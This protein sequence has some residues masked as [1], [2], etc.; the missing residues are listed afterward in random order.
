MA[1]WYGDTKGLM[2]QGRVEGSIRHNASHLTVGAK[3]KVKAN[4]H[5]NHIVVQGEVVG[6]LFGTEAVIIEASARVRGNVFAPRV[7]LHEGAKFKGSIDM[8]GT[9]ES[10]LSSDSAKSSES[11]KSPARSTRKK[12]GSSKDAVSDEQVDELLD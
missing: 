6:D 8:D 9:G 4:V 2:I 11:A 10:K 5:A 3:G 1:M 12:A 7:A